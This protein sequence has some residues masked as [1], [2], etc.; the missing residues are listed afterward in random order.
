M[1]HPVKGR[2]PQ[3]RIYLTVLQAT[4]YTLKLRSV[5]LSRSEESSQLTPIFM[6]RI[7]AM[8]VD[9]SASDRSNFKI[10]LRVGLHAP[11]RGVTWT[12]CYSGGFL[13]DFGSETHRNLARFK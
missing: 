2:E 12:L 8:A 1:S 7:E 13:P 3:R 9:S 5:I 10:V 6:G 4:S 11:L